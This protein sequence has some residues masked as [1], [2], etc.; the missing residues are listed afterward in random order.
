[1]GARR[2]M[3]ADATEKA[4][5]IYRDEG[6]T[7]A[8]IAPAFGVSAPTLCINLKRKEEYRVLAQKRKKE[9]LWWEEWRVNKQKKRQELLARL[10]T[11]RS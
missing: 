3:T 8:Q 5:Q 7:L 9:Q 2:L 1:M 6:K 11:L 10:A 4:W